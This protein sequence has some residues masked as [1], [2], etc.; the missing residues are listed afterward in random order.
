MLFLDERWM[1]KVVDPEIGDC[2]GAVET[3]NSMRV[4]KLLALASERRI[5]L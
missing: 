2:D 5:H 4:T 1:T 3:D